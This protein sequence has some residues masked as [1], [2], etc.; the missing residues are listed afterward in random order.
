M[1][2]NKLANLVVVNGDRHWQYHSVDPESGLN[3]FSCG[4]VSDSHATH[5]PYDLKY[6]RF[7]RIKGGFLTVSLEGTEERPRLL[8]QHH[9]VDGQIVH[10][11][12]FTG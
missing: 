6:H 5:F 4:P 9:E 10:K 2:E 1:R 12:V 11:A 7:L 8:V 3:E